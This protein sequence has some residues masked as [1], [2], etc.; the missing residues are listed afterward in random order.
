MIFNFKIFLLFFTYLFFSCNSF[1]QSYSMLEVDKQLHE[2]FI[3]SDHDFIDTTFH[4]EFT[5]I[6][7]DGIMWPRRESLE[8]KLSPILSE[9]NNIEIIQHFYGEATFLE[10]SIEGTYVMYIWD[11]TSSKPMLLNITE[12]IQKD[13]D[14]SPVMADYEIPC[15]NPCASIPWIPL[16]E[17]QQLAYQAWQD[18]E[19]AYLDPVSGKLNREGWIR[20]INNDQDQRPVNTYMGRAPKKEDRVNYYMPRINAALETRGTG[21]TVPVLWSRWWNIGSNAV[22]NIMLQPTHGDKAYWASRV[23]SPVDDVWL[24]S[25][26]YHTYIEASPIMTTINPNITEDERTDLRNIDL[27]P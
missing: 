19:Q 6:T 18:Q 27:S 26:S 7:A 24:M 23:F 17:N 3:N 22:F 20:R 11:N 13:R 21:F 8:A 12:V 5:W 14:Y 15:V 16:T 1:A 25:E 2:A 4:P 10:R 9:Q